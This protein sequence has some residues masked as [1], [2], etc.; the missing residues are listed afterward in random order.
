M[1][2][3]PV[4]DEVGV[5]LGHQAATSQ[6]FEVGVSEGSS[7][8]VDDL[9][10]VTTP[11]P[12]GEVTTYGIV[13]ESYARMEGASLPSDTA[14]IAAGQM[15]GELVRT[16]DVQ[17][18][19]VEPERWIAAHPGLTVRRAAGADR[20]KA[21]Y[22]DTM[23]RTLSIGLARDGQPIKLDLDF[24]DGTKGGHVSISGISG[25]AT[26]TSTALA[27]VRLLLEHPLMRRRVRV[28]IFNVKGEDL[29]HIDRPNRRYAER[30]DV[31]D[32][33]RRWEALGLA[34]A[35]PF[36]AVGFWA[37]PL[38]DG[39]PSCDS[40]HEGVRAFGWTPLRFAL[41]GLLRFCFAE[42]ADMRNQLS[43]VEERVRAE[44]ARRAVPVSGHPGALGLLDG[45]AEADPEG[46]RERLPSELAAGPFADLREL[47]DWFEANM[48]DDGW[49]SSAEGRQW[50]GPAAAGTTQA[51]LRRLRAAV[52]RLKGLIRAEAH[53]I[54]R[55]AAAAE[56]PPVAVVH[57]T[58]LHEF[59][60]RF[61]VGTLLAQTFEAKAGG[62]RDPIEFVVLDELNKY[63]PREGQSPIKDTL[64]DIAQRGR[65]LGV[66]LV[67][68]QQQASL[69]A[70]EVTQNAAVRISGRLDAAEAER[71]EYGW[72]TPQARARAR[73]LMQGKMLISQPSV[74]ASLAVSIP[75]PPWATTFGEVSQAL[76]AD[77]AFARYG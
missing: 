14:V 43:F 18:M 26:K 20:A 42:A 3:V 36:P 37:P 52:G 4:P 61:V 46:R 69:V 8:E 13:A 57:L 62:T 45:P 50:L 65:S 66:I 63:A 48:S 67:G 21:L 17:V 35:E 55:G 74:P 28:L 58:P 23:E 32:L 47:V 71:A 24:L 68:A 39:R 75:F 27:L 15:P 12:A 60:Q 19:R 41:E 54:P 2:E 5:V 7:L 33:D 64:V 40:R 73:L 9:V 11:D 59:A 70:S 76:R 38:P 56:E 34:A 72:L 31:A 16:A 53:A 10:A 49:A 51:F 29:M 22:E 25:V 1:T 30:P 77:E 44:L 6:S